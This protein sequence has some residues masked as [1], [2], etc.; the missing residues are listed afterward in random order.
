MLCRAFP[1]DIKVGDRESLADI[2]N[3]IAI[4]EMGR[5]GVLQGTPA[6]LG[7]PRRTEIAMQYFFVT[8][9]PKSGTTWL[10]KMLDGH[11]EVVCSGEGTF[12]EGIAKPISD[13]RTAYNAKQKVVGERVYGH[14]SHYPTLTSDD[15]LPAA[16]M[17]IKCLMDKRLYEGVVAVGDKT[18]RHNFYLNT[19]NTIFPECKIINIVRHPYDVTVSKL[20]HAARAGFE[21]VLVPGTASRAEMVEQTA[22]DWSESQ[23]RVLEFKNKNPGR[24]IEV[25]YEALLERA[26]AE[27]ELL[28][29]FIGASTDKSLV[30]AAVNQVSFERLSGGR[31]QG[32][33]D[34][35]SF[36]R[37]GIAGD[38]KNQL[39]H[40]MTLLV[41]KY[42]AALMGSYRYEI[43]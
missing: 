43:A 1:S 31:S 8:G 36:Y 33:E 15:I 34:R 35:S 11:P 10:Q 18:P 3:K 26:A 38:W 24:V 25:T 5:E 30:E 42:C 27:V 9:S 37:K 13:M 40:D 32:V 20:F 28:F 17:I 21:D 6:S 39:D 16:R 2:A 12:I 4:H 22:K 14:R 41:N 23:R 19:I 29:D 7:Q